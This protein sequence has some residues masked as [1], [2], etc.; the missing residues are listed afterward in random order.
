MKQ[1]FQNLH[2][3][4][5]A[6]GANPTN[7]PSLKNKKG[8]LEVRPVGTLPNVSRPKALGKAERTSKQPQSLLPTAT[9]GL[10]HIINFPVN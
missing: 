9:L 5:G 2:F 6:A 10:Y 3:H 7:N 8:C 1:C 4:L